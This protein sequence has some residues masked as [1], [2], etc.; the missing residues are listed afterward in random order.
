MSS[1]TQLVLY[2]ILA[3]TILHRLHRVI[4][5][6]YL[7]PLRSIPGPVLWSISRLPFQIS[8]LR[9]DIHLQ[10]LSLHKKFGSVVRVGPNQ[11]AFFT[12]QSWRDIYGRV[13]DRSFG[14]ERLYYE[15][16]VN[17]VDHLLSAVRDGDHARQ[18]R[19]MAGAFTGEALRAQ[20][21]LIL[22]Y[23]DTLIQRLKIQSG[24]D[25]LDLGAWFNYATFDVTGDLMFGES[26]GCLREGVLHEWIRLAFGA[27]KALTWIGVVKQ[28]PAARWLLVRFIPR[29]VLRMGEDHFRLAAAKADRRIEMGTQRPDFMS[30]I[31]KNGICEEGVRSKELEREKVMTREEIRS[32]AYIMIIAGSETSATA[33]SGISYYLCK[34]R[35][36]LDK[37][38]TEIRGAF[39]DDADITFEATSNLTYLN[40]VIEEGLRMY[41]PVP[42]A[43]HR[44]PPPGG[45]TVDGYFVP[46]G[47]SVATHHYATYHS[48]H[49]FTL[50]DEFIPERWLGDSRFPNDELDAVQ[51]FQL[52]PRGC[53]GK[54]LGYAE[55]RTILSKLLFN[56]DISLCQESEIWVD[57]K[58]Y[59]LWDKRPLMMNLRKRVE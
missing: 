1:P 4:T 56:F 52:G 15:P 2:A 25:P 31:L 58:V 11:L 45:E 46:E 20:E 30:W 55:I 6:L 53:L 28:F 51:A 3:L 48:P 35:T 24:N 29:R 40:A 16:P 13:G 5:L 27:I 49:N 9:G 37:L 42:H 36:V 38:A 17:G 54:A 18:R 7:S 14:K 43:L 50:P 12:A 59:Y 33:L 57:Q 23:I 19:L 10:M 26:F 47:T 22:S 44:L 41:P 39:A 21:P 8:M 32:N 34:N